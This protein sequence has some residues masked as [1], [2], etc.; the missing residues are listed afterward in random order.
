MI[1]GKLN[2]SSKFQRSPEIIGI[3]TVRQCRP[4]KATKAGLK[5]IKN[6]TKKI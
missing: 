3:Y 6:S 4:I 5:K 1:E 2:S